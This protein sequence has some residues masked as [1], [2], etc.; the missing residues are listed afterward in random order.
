MRVLIDTAGCTPYDP[1]EFNELKSIATLEKIEPLLVMPAGGD[2]LEAIDMLEIFSTLPIR[3]LLITRTDAARRFGG[4]L[5]AAAAH[6]LSL[7]NISRSASIMD[8]VQPLEPAI[9]AEMLLRYK[10]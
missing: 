3:R 10:N 1:K 4:I 8:S 6:G 7:C 5:A 2:S 9:L